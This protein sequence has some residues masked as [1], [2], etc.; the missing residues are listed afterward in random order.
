MTKNIILPPNFK[1]LK[2]SVWDS[3]LGKIA[4]SAQPGHDTSGN[5]DSIYLEKINKGLSFE[6]SNIDLD[7]MSNLLAI[8]KMGFFTIYNLVQGKLP[9]RNPQLIKKI[10]EENFNN[11]N[12][13]IKIN[14]V[15][16]SIADFTAPSQTQL[17][18]ITSD[19]LGRLSNG[20]N[21]L[22]HCRGGI[23]RT[24]TILA[25][26]YM[27][28]SKTTNAEEA[29][30]YIRNHYNSKAVET[31]SQLEALQAFGKQLNL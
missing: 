8:H 15:D 4:G 2:G 22:I 24:G 7:L 29:V 28:A 27:K 6:E 11:T 26:L 19:I 3:F 5:M 1:I 31:D 23:G 20:E 14:D 16:T 21:I 13:I 30:K 10:W 9:E 25:A 17:Q 18:L 12:Y